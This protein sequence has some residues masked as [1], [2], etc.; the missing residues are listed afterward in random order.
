MNLSLCSPFQH[1]TTKLAL[2][3]NSIK[4]NM[5]F[6][7]LTDRLFGMTACNN[8]AT[9]LT[10]TVIRARSAL[11]NRMPQPLVTYHNG[12]SAL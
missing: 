8:A 11:L 12:R 9:V 2:N 3:F 7:Q 1:I 10:T 6:T 5:S 4:T